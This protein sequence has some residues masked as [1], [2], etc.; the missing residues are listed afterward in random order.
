MYRPMPAEQRAAY[1][2][3]LVYQLDVVESM[4]AGPYLVSDT[5]TNGDGACRS[6]FCLTANCK[7]SV[8]LTLGPQ[9]L[10]ALIHACHP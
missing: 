1:L 6:L 4:V 7:L 10:R 5:P 9:G 8:C 3:Q 2:T